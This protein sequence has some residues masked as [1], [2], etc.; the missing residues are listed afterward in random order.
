MK[1][2]DE[3]CTGSHDDRK[4]ATL[5]PRTREAK[6]ARSLKWSRDN[7]DKEAERH[8][9]YRTTSAYFLAAARNEAHR[10]GTRETA[11]SD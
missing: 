3:R 9:R 11:K 1:C 8:A 6:L 4:W 5:C 10:R 2:G 7:P